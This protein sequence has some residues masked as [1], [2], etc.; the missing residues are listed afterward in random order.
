MLG[1]IFNNNLEWR[2][3]SNKKSSSNQYLRPIRAFDDVAL[4]SLDSP[5]LI[6]ATNRSSLP[7]NAIK[8]SSS[9]RWTS[10]NAVK[11]N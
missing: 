10:K 5:T 8:R 3:N 6:E 11:R 1:H 7:G 4:I 9:N 2:P